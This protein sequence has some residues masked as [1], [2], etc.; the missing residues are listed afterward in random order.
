MVKII[1]FN[2]VIIPKVGLRLPEG[3]YEG[4]LENRSDLKYIRQNLIIL[5]IFSELR[6]NSSESFNIGLD[7][8]EIGIII[9]LI[10]CH[11]E[12]RQSTMSSLASASG[13]AYGTAHRAIEKLLKEGQIIQRERTSTGRSF[14]L[15]P[16]LDLLKRWHDLSNYTHRLIEISLSSDV[17]YNKAL[18]KLPKQKNTFKLVSPPTV[19]KEKLKLNHGLRVLV[20]ADPTFMA[21]NG[22]KRQFEMIMG[23]D[24]HS[25]ALSIDR[26]R[27]EIVENGKRQISDYDIIACDLPWFGEMVKR[28][29]LLPL[30]SYIKLSDM[31]LSDFIPDAI[32]ST[33]QN[34]QNFG[35]PV[36]STAELLVYR[37]DLFDD[38][39]LQ[40]P[41][42]FQETINAA[43]AL[44]KPQI[45]QYGIA[46]NGGRG[47]ALGHTFM[48]IM[49]AHGQPIIN[50]DPE[51]DG[52]NAKHVIGEHHRPMFLSQA[53]RDCAEYLK[54]LKDYS[55]PDILSTTWYDRA[56][57][58]ST[59]KVAMVYCH[60]LLANLFELDPTSPAYGNAG[61]L[62]QPTQPGGRSISPLGGYA[63][64]IPSN[65]STERASEAWKAIEML[66]SASSAKL[67][68]ANGS[69]ASPRFS[70]NQDPEI[71]SLSPIIGVVDRL[72]KTGVLKM[73]PRPPVPGIS[74]I[75]SIAGE[76][77][78]NY[79][80]NTKKLDQALLDAQNRSDQ[81]MKEHGHY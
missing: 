49:A 6:I 33:I 64:A 30:N 73:W 26:L 7:L 8:R 78:H 48:V 1:N 10:K 3:P 79:L 14:S 46:W 2:K 18:R 29:R 20:H 17:D 4:N 69:L 74:S 59:G 43:K 36:L 32:A 39:Q 56:Q 75:I 45:G 28:K 27:K 76:E 41:T 67:F 21:M 15:H 72:A 71:K 70:I 44:S 23:V 52:F 38:A 66:T 50:L 55:P 16:S 80:S 68:I 13:L 54:E 35:I 12:G 11:Y 31:D 57:N 60:T 65:I 22:L 61:Y 47:T 34:N 62:P 5:N 77:I 81:V 19:L 25:K 37:T 63:L 9:E 24:I 53:A 40:P 42:T 51:S 58:F